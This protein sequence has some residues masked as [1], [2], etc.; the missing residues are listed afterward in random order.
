[1]NATERNAW[2]DTYEKNG[3]CCGFCYSRIKGTGDRSSHDTPVTGGDQISQGLHHQ[4]DGEGERHSLKWQHPAWPNLAALEISGSSVIPIGSLL[5]I[6]LWALDYGSSYDITLFADQDQNPYND[7]SLETIARIAG[8]PATGKDFARRGV[9]WD[10]SSMTNGKPVYIYAKIE[11][12][13]HTRY[14]YA[15]TS[16]LF[17]QA[18]HEYDYYIPLFKASD[19]TWTGMAITNLDLKNSNSFSVTLYAT[20][21]TVLDR[22]YPHPLPAA[23]QTAM[24]VAKN[25]QGAGWFKVSSSKPLGGVSFIGNDTMFGIPFSKNLHKRLVIAHI[26]QDD[27]WDT[28]IYICNP[29]PETASLDIGFTSQ[30][31]TV[32]LHHTALLQKHE[33]GVYP[34]ANLFPDQ[35]L[36]AGSVTVSSNKG[37]AIYTLYSNKKSGGTYT[38]GNNALGLD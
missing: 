3:A 32:A 34:L 10:T 38:T 1:M 6:S 7:N 16:L 25:Y 15:P 8:N 2:F 28:T 17:T 20:D 22:N 31:G 21:G 18:K 33:S 5:Q 19:T 26:A 9:S 35:P 37:I 24:L 27:T 12:P 14:F 23:G 36:L 4:L 29:N 13:N 11:D 30:D